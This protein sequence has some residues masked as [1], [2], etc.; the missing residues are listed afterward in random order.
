MVKV[1][2]LSNATSMK[3]LTS[4]SA[5]LA[6]T[7]KSASLKFLKTAVLSDGSIALSFTAFANPDGSLSNKAN[8]RKSN[9][10]A[11]EYETISVRYWDSYYKLERSSLW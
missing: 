9:S 6:G 11:R 5:Y 2:T 10:T 4:C 8:T 1:Y 3:V 7:I